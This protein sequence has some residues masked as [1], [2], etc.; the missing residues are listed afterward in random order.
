MLYDELQDPEEL[1]EKTYNYDDK[2]I[3]NLLEIEFH[4]ILDS[5][6]D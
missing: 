6:K 4:K 2:S 5:N 3:H 1:L